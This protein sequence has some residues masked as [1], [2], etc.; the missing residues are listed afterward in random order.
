MKIKNRHEHR[1]R[2]LD[3]NGYDVFF[4]KCNTDLKQHTREWCTRWWE[5]HAQ[6]D[7]WPR[8]PLPGS[9]GVVHW[10][11]ELVF[12][13]TSQQ[14]CC[15]QLLADVWIYR[16]YLVPCIVFLGFLFRL[17]RRFRRSA[18]LL[19]RRIIRGLLPSPSLECKS[20]ILLRAYVIAG[21]YVWP[22]VVL[23]GPTF[24]PNEIVRLSTSPVSHP[25][26]AEFTAGRVS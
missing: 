25:H 5:K 1:L 15:I 18:I 14:R 6:H 10:R 12:L 3:V 7:A 26:H 21:V 8:Q 2:V 4:K 24:V 9:R 13:M 19:V 23:N 11:V 16:Y 17:L 20:S 22:T